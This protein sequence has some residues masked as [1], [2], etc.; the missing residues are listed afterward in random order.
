MKMIVR[1]GGGHDVVPIGLL[2]VLCTARRQNFF[3]YALAMCDSQP[4]ENRYKNDASQTPN[5]MLRIANSSSKYYA[6]AAALFPV[7]C[8]QRR[9]CGGLKDIVHSVSSE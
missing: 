1:I 9:S 5:K 2:S 3:S 6:A 4:A 8:Q 7:D